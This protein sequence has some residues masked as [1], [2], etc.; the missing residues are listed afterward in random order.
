MSVA[1][2]INH[3]ERAA[4]LPEIAFGIEMQHLRTHAG[5]AGAPLDAVAA[6]TDQIAQRWVPSGVWL[7][8]K[9]A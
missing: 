2:R 1:T 8:L 7:E 6:A 3:D 5:I 4:R 9:V